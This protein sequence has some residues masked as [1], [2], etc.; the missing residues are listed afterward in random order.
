MIDCF[1]SLLNTDNATGMQLKLKMTTGNT[2]QKLNTKKM[3]L[4]DLMSKSE[5]LR[6]E[7][8]A[9]QK[10]VNSNTFLYVLLDACQCGL[11]NLKHEL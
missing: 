1:Q 7:I 9:R 8:A 4:N 3:S 10:Q 5:W 6:S 11:S 2:V